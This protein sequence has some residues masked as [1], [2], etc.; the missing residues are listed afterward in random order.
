LSYK[1]L[2]QGCFC[3]PPAAGEALELDARELA[4]LLEGLDVALAEQAPRRAI[5]AVA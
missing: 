4:L 1:R 2:E 5:L 3:I